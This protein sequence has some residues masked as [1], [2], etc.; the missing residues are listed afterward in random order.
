MNTIDLYNFIQKNNITDYKDPLLND[1]YNNLYVSDY[2][3]VAL[4]PFLIKRLN[5]DTFDKYRGFVR[6]VNTSSGRSNYL[7]ISYLAN[8][9]YTPDE[10]YEF[11]NSLDMDYCNIDVLSIATI[12]YFSELKK[13]H[14]ILMALNKNY[15]TF[16]YSEWYQ[17]ID[18]E[19]NSLETLKSTFNNIKRHDSLLILRELQGKNIFRTPDFIDSFYDMPF[20]FYKDSDDKK[21]L[22]FEFTSKYLNGVIHFFNDTQEW[23]SIHLLKLIDLVYHNDIDHCYGLK[24]RTTL[25][26]LCDV[27]K[28][29]NKFTADCISKMEHLLNNIVST[30]LNHFDSEHFNFS[31]TNIKYSNMNIDTFNALSIENKKTVLSHLLMAGLDILGDDTDIVSFDKINAVELIDDELI[32]KLINTI[33]SN[34]T[35]NRRSYNTADIYNFNVRMLAFV[36]ELKTPIADMILSLVNNSKCNALTLIKELRVLNPD[37]FNKRKTTRS[38]SR[39]DQITSILLGKNIKMSNSLNVLGINS[40]HSDFKDSTKQMLLTFIDNQSDKSYIM[41]L[42]IEFNDD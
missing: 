39:L 20:T 23:N 16:F 26:F 8:Y 3:H 37:K 12:P 28:Y 38:D 34:D 14:Q 25:A 2:N 32:Y 36:K 4:M 18:F 9:T 35:L 29:K 19:L 6:K 22:S 13:E 41:D 17:K 27:M 1:I 10:L 15:S 40:R 7:F 31:Y 42:N 11:L 5:V 30:H 24:W 21:G 33:D